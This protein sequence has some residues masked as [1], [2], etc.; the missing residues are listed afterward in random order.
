VRISVFNSKELQAVVLALR[1]FDK[2]M[3]TNVRRVTK[4]LGTPEWQA[5]VRGNVASRLQSRVLG[6]TARVQASDQTVMLK[7]AAIGRALSGGARPPAVWA[8]AEL[9]AFPK[10]ATVTATSRRGKRYT[11]SRN[12][13]AQFPA[14]NRKGYVVFPAAARMIP[15]FAALWA[16]TVVRT[17]HEAMEA[18]N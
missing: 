12:V 8:G 18:K 17:F 11:Y 9:G 14:R 6:D 1:T 10:R 15:R 5:Q 3:K 16:Q 13:N 4:I 7:A 2:T